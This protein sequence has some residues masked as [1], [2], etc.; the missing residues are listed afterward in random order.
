MR[1][2][3]LIKALFRR[4]KKDYVSSRVHQLSSGASRAEYDQLSGQDQLFRRPKA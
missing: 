1:I 3:R 2:K 4:R